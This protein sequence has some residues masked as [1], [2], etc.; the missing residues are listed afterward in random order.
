[1]FPLIAIVDTRI[2]NNGAGIDNILT[3]NIV[4]NCLKRVEETFI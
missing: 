3:I 2:G 1:M 4:N